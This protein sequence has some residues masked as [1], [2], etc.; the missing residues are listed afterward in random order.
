MNSSPNLN[1]RHLISTLDPAVAS[2]TANFCAETV[3]N[4]V[5]K[6]IHTNGRNFDHN[7]NHGNFQ[8]DDVFDDS[9]PLPRENLKKKLT[10]RSVSESDKEGLE[11][12]HYGST[13]KHSDL[14]M[15][16]STPPPGM[17]TE[18]KI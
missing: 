17:K 5:I 6:S 2:V 8:K 16:L 12:R 18:T 13:R 14:T 9:E 11:E 10:K 15:C 1:N 4:P 3:V 7:S